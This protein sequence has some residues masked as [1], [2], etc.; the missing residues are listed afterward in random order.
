[1][2]CGGGDSR[3]NGFGAV[4]G[5][6][7]KQV[8]EGSMLVKSHHHSLI[9]STQG[10]NVLLKATGTSAQ[11]SLGILQGFSLLR[12]PEIWPRGKGKT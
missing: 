8:P 2:C 7:A 4:Q 12:Q 11:E 5:V 1:M 3:F 9:S 10:Q 6:L